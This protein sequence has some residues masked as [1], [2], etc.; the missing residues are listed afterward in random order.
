MALSERLNRRAHPTIIL[1]TLPYGGGGCR[2]KG[3]R[4]AETI[5]NKAEDEAASRGMKMFLGCGMRMK[6]SLTEAVLL[7]VKT[8]RLLESD[9][10]TKGGCSASLRININILSLLLMVGSFCKST[11]QLNLI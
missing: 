3:R 2:G 5:K 8:L 11:N 4:K 6:N 1:D 10:R 9:D 7:K